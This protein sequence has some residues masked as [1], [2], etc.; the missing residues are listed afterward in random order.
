MKLTAHSPVASCYPHTFG[1][2]SSPARQ[3]GG[4]RGDA[5][6]KRVEREGG[7]KGK[8]RAQVKRAKSGRIEGRREE[9]AGV[10]RITW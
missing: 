1:F 4:G 9:K 2:H 3:R 10:V 5:N 8:L 7:I 6:Y